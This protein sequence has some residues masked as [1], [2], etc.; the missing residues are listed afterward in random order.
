MSHPVR[1]VLAAVCLV[2]AVYVAPAAAKPPDRGS[3]ARSADRLPPVR[4][5]TADRRAAPTA[6]AETTALGRGTAWWGSDRGM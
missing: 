2:S 5:G 6:E 1:T 3:A 4:S